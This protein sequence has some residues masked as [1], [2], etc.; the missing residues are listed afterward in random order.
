VGLVES[1]GVTGRYR[2]W[3]S[4]EVSPQSVKVLK[5]WKL[6]LDSTDLSVDPAT[7]L[8]DDRFT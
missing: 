5:P 4:R 6:R 2:T 1:C 8:D 7:L 3:S